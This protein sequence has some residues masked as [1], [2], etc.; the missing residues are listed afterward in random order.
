M[1]DGTPPSETVNVTDS[2][3]FTIILTETL[4]ASTTTSLTPSSTA[5]V[6]PTPSTEP[7]ITT[8]AAPPTNRSSGPPVGLIVG[9]VVGGLSGLL[10]LA[11]LAFLFRRKG[12]KLVKKAP[13]D[14]MDIPLVVLQAKTK[15]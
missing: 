12:G 1:V 14:D 5:L 15:K 10:V 2:Y 13:D 11:V 9:P 8:T 4:P 6:Q 3:P 7:A